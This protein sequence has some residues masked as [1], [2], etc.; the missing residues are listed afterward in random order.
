MIAHFSTVMVFIG[1]GILALQVLGVDPVYV[2][3]S[4]G[5]VGFAL[6]ISGQEIIRNLLS[7]T[8]ALLE[9]RYAVSDEVTFTVG[10]TDTSGTVDLIG[11]TSVRLRTS[12]GATW[13][14][15]HSSIE[16]VT[17]YS[18]IAASAEI[19]VPTHRWAEVEDEATRRLTTASNDIG[20]TGVVFLPDLATQLHP[21]GVT[22]V[23]VR[24][25]RP[26]TDD[27]KDLVHERLTQKSRQAIRPTSRQDV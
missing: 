9:D 16:S 11:A 25:N 23:T 7:G 1:A 21:T 19:I 5:F 13:H 3:S 27:Q 22:S 12:S 24:S 17:N 6:A 14:T 20:L 26:L 18:Q 15:G 2:I 10:G 8:I 4:A